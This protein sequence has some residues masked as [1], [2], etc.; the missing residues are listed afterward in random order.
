MT[1]AN[2]FRA[3]L[4]RTLL[5]ENT[6]KLM[7]ATMHAHLWSDFTAN[8]LFEFNVFEFVFRYCI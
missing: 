4:P 3:F 5:M 1:F 2:L 7:T 6:T 8:K